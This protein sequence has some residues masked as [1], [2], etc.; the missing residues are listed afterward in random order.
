MLLVFQCYTLT[1]RSIA[2]L[3]VAEFQARALIWPIFNSLLALRILAKN[4]L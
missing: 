1:V 4:R 2:A 3:V